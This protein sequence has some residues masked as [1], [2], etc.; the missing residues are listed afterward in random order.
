MFIK[1]LLH[2]CIWYSVRLFSLKKNFP[3][4]FWLVLSKSIS[5]LAS[6]LSCLDFLPP[7]S[8]GCLSWCLWYIPSSRTLDLSLTLFPPSF[9]WVPSPCYPWEKVHGKHT[10]QNLVSDKVCILPLYL[11]D[12]LI[13]LLKI[14]WKLPSLTILKPLI[15]SSFQS[16]FWEIWSLTILDH[17]YDIFLKLLN[18]LSVSSAEKLD[19]NMLWCESIF[20][21]C[22]VYLVVF[23]SRNSGHS[24]LRSF[25][26][27]LF[28]FLLS[29]S[30]CSLFLWLLFLRW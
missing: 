29:N 2:T 26:N 17:W 27:Y 18:L 5:R 21:H 12:K 9:W 24:F 25:L 10:F 4:G 1:A 20:I 15:S 3:K 7:V 13:R 8:L 14:S 16:W 30:F 6:E 28:D 11:I 19:E 22:V 23:Q